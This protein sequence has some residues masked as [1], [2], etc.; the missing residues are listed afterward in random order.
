MTGQ[1]T[2]RSMA[3][4]YTKTVKAGQVFFFEGDSADEMYIIKSGSVSVYKRIQNIDNEIATLTTGD[5]F[6]EMSLLLNEHRSATIKAKEDT[7]VVVINK[8]TFSEMIRENSN[9]AVKM[10]EKLADRIKQTDDRLKKI[11]E[12]R[13]LIALLT[14]LEDS[15]LKGQK[16]ADGKL[17]LQESLEDLA[18]IVSLPIIKIDEVLKKFQKSGFIELHQNQIILKNWKSFMEFKKTYITKYR[19]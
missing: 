13:V 3:D 5:F 2:G 17:I 14:I 11:M 7:T 10:I 9:I 18:R 16:T 19:F 1:P 12:D 15:A 8:S 4:K 6:G